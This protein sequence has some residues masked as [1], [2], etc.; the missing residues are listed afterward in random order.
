MDLNLNYAD[1]AIGVMLA[2]GFIRG[3]LAGF[4]A[5]VLNLAGT[6]A[7]FIGAYFLTAP[8]V[9]YLERASGWVTRVTAWWDDI[10]LLI[11]NYSKAYD[12]N[13]VADFFAGIDSTPWLRPIS[14]LIKDRFLE[15]EATA[16][17][18]ASWG[19]IL[20]SLMAQILV[21]GVVFFIL[22][23]V[24]RFA[25]SLF[26]RT[27]AFATA[28]S[29]TQRIL[30]GL[31]QTG[32]SLVWLSLVIG[33]LYPLVGLEILGPVRDVVASSHLVEILLG[34]YQALIPAVL[35]KISP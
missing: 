5:S 11:P 24:L 12:P 2:L 29:L 9:N 10:F 20:S 34:I 16:G 23:T 31:L 17:P 28:L 15:I 14:A 6:F 32:L 3:F 4:W 35:L 30:G 25:W 18:G 19:S 13:A 21:S 22:L 7:S 8:A 1:L 26:S 27:I 33:A